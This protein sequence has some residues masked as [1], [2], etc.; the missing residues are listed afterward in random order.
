VS[1]NS[2][3]PYLGL[4]NIN[5]K[6]DTWYQDYIANNARTDLLGK[7]LRIQNG[8]GEP[9]ALRLALLNGSLVDAIKVLPQ[10]DGSLQIYLGRQNT[11]DVVYLAG[12]PTKTSV[13]ISNSNP[14]SVGRNLYL[15][16][17]FNAAVDSTFLFDNQDLN[18]VRMAAPTYS[19]AKFMTWKGSAAQLELERTSNTAL[20]WLLNFQVTISGVAKTFVIPAYAV[21]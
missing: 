4:R 8:N 11:K 21:D 17:T 14:S 5:L 20:P 10:S 6:S 2:L 3:T 9:I 16:G 12:D 19:G 15:R 1:Y 18:E 7:H 13:K